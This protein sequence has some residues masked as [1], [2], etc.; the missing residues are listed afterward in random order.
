MCWFFVS[1]ETADCTNQDGGEGVVP[2][3]PPAHVLGSVR[4]AGQFV[5]VCVYVCVCVWREKERK[6]EREKEREKERKKEKE[7]RESEKRKKEKKRKSLPIICHYG[8]VWLS[9]SSSPSVFSL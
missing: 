3:H 1:S 5:C 9:P 6:K 2:L 4:P 8:D 7:K